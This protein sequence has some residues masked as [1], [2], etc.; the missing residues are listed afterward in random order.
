M[1]YKIETG[2]PMPEAPHQTNK[3]RRR[4]NHSWPWASMRR[5]ESVTMSLADWRMGQ[6]A[7]YNY[8]TRTGKKFEW[9]AQEY[10]V[11]IW[12][13][14]MPVPVVDHRISWPFST[15]D[16]G[17]SVRYDRV[18]WKKGRMASCNY[19]KRSGK[20]FKWERGETTCTCTRIA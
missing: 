11:R 5:G 1:K 13:T 10:T 7:M 6:P 8:T 18:L 9:I 14:E 20:E 3:S 17:A 15:M 2:V 19:S 12:C 16:I 4:S